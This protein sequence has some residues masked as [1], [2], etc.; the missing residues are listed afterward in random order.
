MDDMSAAQKA[1]VWTS[2]PP[3]RPVNGK[4]FI[5][6]GPDTLT[7]EIVRAPG[8][9]SCVQ[10]LA[11]R[12]GLLQSHGRT[13]DDAPLGRRGAERGG[14]GPYPALIARV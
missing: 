11:E 1:G 7:L 5:S 3:R 6:F 10:S 2:A 8:L 9:R 14:V 4:S 12:P 13:A